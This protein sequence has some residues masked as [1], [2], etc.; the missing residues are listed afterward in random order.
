MHL[1]PILSDGAGDVRQSCR[2]GSDFRRRLCRN[3]RQ[4]LLSFLIRRIQPRRQHVG[5]HAQERLRSIP[6]LPRHMLPGLG[7]LGQPR[8]RRRLRRNIKKALQLDPNLYEANYFYGR[9][10]RA[11]GDHERAV[12]L[13][14]RAAEVRPTDYKAL[15][16]LQS[17]YEL[18]QAA[19]A[20]RARVGGWSNGQ[21]VSSQ[22]RPENAVAA[23][24]GAMALAAMGEKSGR[25]SFSNS[26]CQRSPMIRQFCSTR[27]APTPG[28]ASSN[29]RLISSK[30]SIRS[31]S[32]RTRLGRD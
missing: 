8:D 5:E 3:S 22:S 25:G 2:A 4:R 24:H 11:I 21:S 13:F 1:N 17:V 16:V 14:E 15:G 20:A 29:G 7:M 26:H 9:F 32:P 28:W 6:I 12:E 30:R 23:I 27:P 19:A 31:S 10:C 18:L